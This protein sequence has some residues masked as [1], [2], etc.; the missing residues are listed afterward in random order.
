MAVRKMNPRLT[1]K[2]IITLVAQQSSLTK[3]Q[4]EECFR[5]YAELY[6]SLLGSENTPNDFTMPLPYIG[7]FKMRKYEGMKKG[8]TYK[9]KENFTKESKLITKVCEEDRP[10]FYL[11]YFSISDKYKSTRKEVSK[12]MWYKEK[13][14]NEQENIAT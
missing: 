6:M 12:S 3:A 8:S 2:D 1:T 9:I 4:V 13:N 5:T 11:P 10:D 14:K 7:T